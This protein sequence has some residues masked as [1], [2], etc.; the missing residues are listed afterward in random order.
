MPHA[1]MHAQ[2]ARAPRR[3]PRALSPISEAPEC[4]GRPDW[5][6]RTA[7][8]TAHP[9]R[10]AHD[11]SDPSGGTTPRPGAST[12]DESTAEER[13]EC[14]AAAAR[15][16]VNWE[17]PAWRSVEEWPAGRQ[18]AGRFT[19]RGCADLQTE[20]VPAVCRIRDGVLTLSVE[21]RGAAG[22]EGT[23][24]VVAE[25]PCEVLAVGLRR[26]RTSML[27]LATVHKNEMFDEIYCSCD[28]PARRNRWVA[29]F[30]RMGV[31]VFDLPH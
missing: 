3:S 13:A 25:V 23:E 19:L 26:G 5:E 21:Q 11:V 9:E 8:A 6:R 15:A 7:A 14:A 17:L 27:T 29:V 12:A 20:G 16:A 28:N 31:A 18:A 4:T 24:A 10:S 30:R 22:D 1:S 2:P